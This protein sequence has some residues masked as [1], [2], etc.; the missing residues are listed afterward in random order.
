MKGSF[1]E[2]DLYK[3]YQ[4]DEHIFEIRYG[5][6][7]PEERGMIEPLPIFPDLLKNPVYARDGRSIVTR[8]QVPCEHYRP[9]DG[10]QLEDWCGDC[11]FYENVKQEIAKCLCEKKRIL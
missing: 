9:V 3:V 5:Y 1:A 8:I 10:E 11:T 4:L 2:G 7:E 6:Y